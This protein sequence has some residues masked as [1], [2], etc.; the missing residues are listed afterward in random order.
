MQKKQQYQQ[1]ENKLVKYKDLINIP[2]QENGNVFV[3]LP[4]VAP[5]NYGVI[6]KYE[7]LIDMRGNFPLIPVRKEVK[8]KLDNVDKELK[9]INKN[10][11]LN[12]SS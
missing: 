7:T 4:Q 8:E 5:S 10:Y 1:L 11:Q 6:G 3:E 2:V 12:R 9:K